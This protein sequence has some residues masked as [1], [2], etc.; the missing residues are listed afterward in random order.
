MNKYGRVINCGAISLYNKTETPTGPRAETTLIK[1]SILMQGF[2]VR[3]FVKDFG[4]A[5]KQ[6]AAWM[7]ADKLEYM[8]TVVEGFHNIPQAFID[9]FEGKNKGKM[10]VAV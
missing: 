6:L 3:D 9:L 2:T 5:Q 1:N 8:E 4:P 10:I 7:E